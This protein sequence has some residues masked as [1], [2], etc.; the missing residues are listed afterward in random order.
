MSERV[1]AVRAAPQ[2]KPFD[3]LNGKAKEEETPSENAFDACV[4]K[5]CNSPPPCLTKIKCCW[6]TCERSK[7]CSALGRCGLTFGETHRKKIMYLAAFLSFLSLIF[8]AIAVV[9]VSENIAPIMNVPWSKGEV[10]A[11][12]FLNNATLSLLRAKGVSVGDDKIYIYIGL[13]SL[14][15]DSREIEG[16]GTVA[17]NQLRRVA[18]R[19]SDCVAK[20]A[21]PAACKAC[22]EIAMSSTTF[23]ILALITTIPQLQTDLLRAFGKNDVRCQKAF[24]IV[25]GLWGMYSNLMPLQQFN[26]ACRVGLNELAHATWSPGLGLQCIVIATFLKAIDVLCHMLVPVPRNVENLAHATLVPPLWNGKG[27]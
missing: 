15:V 21:A 22:Q 12:K 27:G 18:W 20:V 17:I 24:G 13:N 2:K 10:D 26:L 9:G 19:E 16:L 23:T 14:V 1:V 8:G 7:L 5:R 3:S 25:T 4:I 11:S 6:G